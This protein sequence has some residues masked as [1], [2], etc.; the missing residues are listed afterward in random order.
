MSLKDWLGKASG[1]RGKQKAGRELSVGDL[2]NL[3]RFED[4]AQFQLLR[5]AGDLLIPRIDFVEPLKQEAAHFVNCVETGERPLSDGKNG[6]DVVRVLEAATRSRRN[7]GQP[8]R[9]R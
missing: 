9:L 3:G 7:E 1:R 5:R 6:L 2:V 4:F 8:E